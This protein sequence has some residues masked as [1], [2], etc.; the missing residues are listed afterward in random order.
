MSGSADWTQFLQPE[1]TTACSA[2]SVGRVPSDCP[3]DSQ[4]MSPLTDLPSDE[5]PIMRE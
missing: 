3:P 1:R 5:C 2:R 4:R